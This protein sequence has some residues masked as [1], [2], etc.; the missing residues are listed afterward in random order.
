MKSSSVKKPSEFPKSNATQRKYLRERLEA[1]HYSK[2]DHDEPEPKDVSA[3][4]KLIERWDKSVRQRR[5]EGDASFERAR[6]KAK[7]AIL[8]DSAE[9][10]LKFVVAYELLVESR[11]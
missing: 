3:A 1:V 7:E 5:N 4:R 2:Y 8:F 11:Q 10:A 9:N 6:T